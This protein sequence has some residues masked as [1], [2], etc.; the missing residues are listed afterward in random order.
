MSCLEKDPTLR[1]QG[2]GELARRLGALNLGAW[3][4]ERAEEWWRGVS[5]S[6]PQVPDAETWAFGPREAGSLRLPAREGRRP[7]FTSEARIHS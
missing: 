3:S 7:A 4:T 6:P 2:A 5:L 1:P